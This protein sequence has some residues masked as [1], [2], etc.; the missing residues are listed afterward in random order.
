MGM[1]DGDIYKIKNYNTDLNIKSINGVVI[2]IIII[3]IIFIRHIHKLLLTDNIYFE[4]DIF[5]IYYL[6]IKKETTSFNQENYLG[7]LII[8]NAI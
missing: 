7:I 2:Y 6:L 4:K 3:I 8:L 5:H 1:H